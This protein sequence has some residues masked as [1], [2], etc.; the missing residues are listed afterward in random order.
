MVSR[1]TS[2]LA[3]L[4]VAIALPATHPVQAVANNLIQNGS[5]ETY[6]KAPGTW[7]IP[8]RV[9]FDLGV[10]NTDITGWTVIKGKIDYF[11][12][13][14]DNPPR[15]WHAADG[16]NSLELAGSPSSGGV[17]QTFATT[18]GERY[19]VQFQMSGSPMTGWSGEDQPRKTVRARAAGQFADF[20]FDVA[21]AQNT[22]ADMKWKLCTFTFVAEADSTTLEIFSTMDPVHIGPVIDDV[23]VMAAPNWSPAGSYMLT[24]TL[25]EEGLVTITPL[26][27]D[28]TRFA[29]VSDVISPGSESRVVARGELLKTGPDT[30]AAT[31]L[32]YCADAAAQITCRFVVSGTMVQTG[33]DTLEA[34]WPGSALFAPD[35]DP[36]ADDAVPLTCFP[37]VLALYERIPVVAPC[38]AVPPTEGQ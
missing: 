23:C 27:S 33:P 7:S 11:G 1:K 8:D 37:E 30:Y 18:P 29:L 32:T 17:S 38:A 2:W 3:V 4:I 9:D 12:R 10:G 25:G 16:D 20:A 6:A 36:F 5:F 34:T 13:C 21:A 26:G 35:Q 28:N 24:D 14:P 15:I 19:H 22:L 31:Q